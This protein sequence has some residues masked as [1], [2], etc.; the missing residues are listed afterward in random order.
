MPSLSSSDYRRYRET[1]AA[2][3]P[4]SPTFRRA[5][6]NVVRGPV[7][8]GPHEV[9]MGALRASVGYSLGSDGDIMVVEHGYDRVLP[10]ILPSGYVNR[11]DYA[12]GVVDVGHV[13]LLPGSRYYAAALRALRAT[14]P[15]HSR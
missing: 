1:L 5:P 10:R 7:R 15:R 14:H 9:R 3:G 8:F 13:T 4:V 12:S 6:A 2:L 11:T